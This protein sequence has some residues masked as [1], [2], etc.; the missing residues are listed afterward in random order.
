[1]RSNRLI[2]VGAIIALLISSS[3]PT[4]ADALTNT[5]YLPLISSSPTTHSVDVQDDAQSLAAVYSEAADL[6][7]IHGHTATNSNIYLPLVTQTASVEPSIS[8]DQDDV[9]NAA[10]LGWPLFPQ[11]SGVDY[12]LNIEKRDFDAGGDGLQINLLFLPTILDLLDILLRSENTSKKVWGLENGQFKAAQSLSTGSGVTVAVLDTG[13][14]VL[15]FYL[16]ARAVAGYDFVGNDRFPYESP[17]WRDDDRDGEIDEG[18]GHGTFVS[19][20]IFAAARNARVMPVRVLNSDGNGTPEIVAKGIRYAADHGADIINLSLSSD[21]DDA[22][23]RDAIAYAADKG[24]VI[25]AAALS[26]SSEV[27]FPANYESVLSVGAIDRSSSIPGFALDNAAQIDI[28][29]PGDEIY[30]PALYGR[31]VWMSGNS[32]AT[33]FVSAAAALLM[34]SG[35]C[36]ADCVTNVLTSNVNPI[37]PEQENRGRVDAYQ[38]LLTQ[39]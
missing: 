28:F 39:Q 29:A 36:P 24:I 21:M 23:V 38:A 13:I 15:P 9:I 35:S 27:G 32:M 14:T 16:S 7:V 6:D 11:T 26:N 2:L 17:N 10:F 20:I 30:G 33:A 3:L 18:S 8:A 5:V 31:N 34:E 4:R 19:S 25:V 22:A 12:S 37:A 1:M